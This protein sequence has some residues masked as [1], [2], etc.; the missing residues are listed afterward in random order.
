VTGPRSAVVFNPVK[1]PDLD[2]LQRTIEEGWRRRAGPAGLAGD[3][4]E[5]AGAASGKAIED[6]AELSSSAAATAR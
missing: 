5:D 6:G 1:V 2:L 3:H 4:P